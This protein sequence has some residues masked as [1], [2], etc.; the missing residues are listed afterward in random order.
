MADGGGPTCLKGVSMLIKALTALAMAAIVPAQA[1]PSGHTA[2]DLHVAAASDDAAR[3][4][5]LVKHGV[6]VDAVVHE[7][8]TPLMTAASNNAA[9]SAQKLVELKADVNRRT[10]AGWT[11]LLY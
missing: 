10:A 11:A 8:V 4:A 3:V 5:T 2:M 9:V 1:A 7:G 6:P